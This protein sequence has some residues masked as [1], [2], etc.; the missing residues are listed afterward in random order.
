MSLGLKSLRLQTSCLQT[1]IL[2]SLYV[3]ERERECVYMCVCGWVYVCVFGR[4][5][6]V[7]KAMRF[8]IC[9]IYITGLFSN[10]QAEF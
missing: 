9:N 1:F 6:F 5:V 8:L 10:T 7:A 2:L 3:C 4:M